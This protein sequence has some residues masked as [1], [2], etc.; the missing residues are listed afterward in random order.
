MMATRDTTADLVR[1]VQSIAQCSTQ[2]AEI[3]ER[4]VTRDAQIEKSTEDTFAQLQ[5]QSTKTG[6]LVGLSAALV[7]SVSIFTLPEPHTN[8]AEVVAI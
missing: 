4:L 7:S 3:S 6:H 5:D 1:L 8:T 2:Q